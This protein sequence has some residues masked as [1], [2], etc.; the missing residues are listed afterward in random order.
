MLNIRIRKYWKNSFNSVLKDKACEDVER[1]EQ[2]DDSGEEMSKEELEKAHKVATKLKNEGN[3]FVQQQKW[4][5][6]IKCYTRAIK[7]FPYDAVFYANRA[8]CQLKIDK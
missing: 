8:L 5:D 7:A 6:A 4:V 1:E 3:I 2:S